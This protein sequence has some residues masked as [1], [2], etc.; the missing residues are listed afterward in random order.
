M[1]FARQYFS[2]ELLRLVAPLA[3]AQIV[4][5]GSTVYSFP[6]FLEP[7][8]REFAWSRPELTGAY[9]L[10]LLV[11]GLCAFPVGWWIDRQGGHIPMTL[12][13]ILAA[14][15]FLAWSEVTALW[16]FYAIWIGLGA[17]M[18]ATLYE[19]VFAVLVTAFR[20]DARRAITL[21][22]LIAGFAGTVFYP[23]TQLLITTLGW[24]PALLV[25]ALL[26]LMVSGG[27]HHFVLRR[28][29]PAR[30]KAEPSPTE[31]SETGAAAVTSPLGAAL[32][33]PSFWLLGLAFV[34]TTLV[35][36]AL[37]VHAIPLLVE[38][39]FELA[40]VIAVMTLVGPMQVAG[41]LLFATVERWV[42]F[43]A[44][45]VITLA[46]PLAAI[47]LLMVVVPGSNWVFAYAFLFGTAAGISTIIRASAVPEFIGTVGYGAINGA[48]AVPTTMARALGPIL[49]AL[50]WG[51]TGGYDAVLWM[52][53]PVAGLSVVGFYLAAWK[54]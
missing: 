21:M 31:A 28:T 5:W 11:A 25:L 42:D 17:V 12:G 19:P 6:L 13:S 34:A 8:E 4:S 9:S 40:L 3:L 1:A 33:H 10:S 27:I 29:A 39:G 22:T 51:W 20:D 38:R 46:L 16:A 52:M 14:L 7:M 36:S 30:A 48:L 43:T 45:G 35:H 23:T 49:A 53:L 50:V 2:G 47:G 37:I 54:S 18:A 26:N 41:R 44:S 32:R 15:L 24:R